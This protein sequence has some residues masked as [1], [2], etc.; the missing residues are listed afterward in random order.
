MPNLQRRL[1]AFVHEIRYAAVAWRDFSA[2]SA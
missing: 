1:H 2:F